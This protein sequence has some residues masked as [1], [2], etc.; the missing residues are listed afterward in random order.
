MTIFGAL[1]IFAL[2]AVIAVQIGKV[3]DLAA[4]IRGEE[5]VERSNN[6]MHAR[7]LVVFMIV[8]LVGCIY[9][10]WHYK[11]MMLGYGPWEAS[12]AHGK[13]V[14]S[15]FNTTLIFTGIVFVITHILLFWYAY[16]YRMQQGRKATFC[17]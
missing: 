9:S 12:S 2:I 14:D 15:I 7:W 17:P 16:K 1:I 4:K 6:D 10:A 13:E 3:N 11:D 8:F 5:A